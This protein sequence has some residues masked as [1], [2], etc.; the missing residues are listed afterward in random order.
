MNETI[1]PSRPPRR[2]LFVDDDPLVSRTFRRDVESLSRYEVHLAGSGEDALAALGDGAFGVVL[3]DFDMPGMN[4]I[5]VLEKVRDGTPDTTRVLVTGRGD[6][7]MAVEVIN[8]VGLFNLVCK[9]WD[10]RELMG[11][12]DRAMR[13]HELLVENRRLNAEL[14]GKV[15]ELGELNR[16]LESE[17]QHRTTHLLLGLI[18]ALDLRDTETQSHSRRVALYSRRLAVELGVAGET[19]QV[20]ERGALLHDIGKIGVSDTILLKPGKLTD[21]EWVEM[22]KHSMYGYRI[23]EGIPFLD[24]ARR[25]VRDHHE[26]WDGNGYP[27][28]LEGE[29]ICLGARVF[30]VV[31]TYDAMTTDRPYR[32]ALPHAIATEEIEQMQGSQF[33]PLVVDAWRRIPQSQLLRLRQ[34]AE[35]PEQRP[36]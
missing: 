18:N 13:H 10:A 35:K 36:L 24:E 34:L 9:P 7:Q 30:A 19:L 2:V 3:C 1:E 11:T 16:T 4:G 8:R 26:R 29:R 27:N 15:A 23:L 6:F 31:D 5:E 12:L 33:D 25:I 17:V 32:K 21:E 14:A 20:I 22:R 28:R